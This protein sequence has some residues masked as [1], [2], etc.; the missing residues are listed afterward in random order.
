MVLAG[1][2]G[3]HDRYNWKDCVQTDAQ[4]KED[5]QKFKKALQPF[6]PK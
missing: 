4:D 3:I 6:L 2:L 5:A 1:L